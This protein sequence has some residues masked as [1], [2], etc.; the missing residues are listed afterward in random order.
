[1]SCADHT[2]CALGSLRIRAVVPARLP[3]DDPATHVRT[4]QCEHRNS[5]GNLFIVG[6]D[7]R[8]ESVEGGLSPWGCLLKHMLAAGGA[9]LCVVVFWLLAIGIRRLL[10]D[11]TLDPSAG[12][13]V[14]VLIAI[15]VYRAIRRIGD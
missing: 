4:L 2:R 11:S 10:P 5:L 8:G 15:P 14:G 9:A 6:K 1:V 3:C 7:R 12:V 13:V